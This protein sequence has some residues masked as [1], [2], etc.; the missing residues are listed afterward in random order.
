[1]V[2]ATIGSR[3]TE[4]AGK[5]YGE[6]TEIGEADGSILVVPVG[7]IEQHGDHLPVS[8]DT[9]L[10]DAAAHGGVEATDDAVPVLVTPPVWSGLSAHHMPFGGT[11]TLSF[12][13]MRGLLKSVADS[14][15]EN[16]FDA[17]LFLNGHGGNMS[18]VSTVVSDVGADHPDVEVLGLSYFY[19]VSDLVAEIRDSDPGG[20]MHAGEF[21]T[22]LM[23]HLRPELVDEDELT[24]VYTERRY[25]WLLDDLFGSGALSAYGTFADY[26]D[27]GVMGDPAAASAEK[28][29]QLFARISEAL[30]GLL[31]AVN[32]ELRSSE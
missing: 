15:L 27:T 21:E 4:W 6:I 22:S 20:M 7:S 24:P 29:E 5:T 8:T 25:E 9:I 1:M 18:L 2:Y 14:A 19:L 26:T 10:A 23:L 28:G 30:A 12:E 31:E 3:E 13:Q 16:G 17:I 32:E 11:L